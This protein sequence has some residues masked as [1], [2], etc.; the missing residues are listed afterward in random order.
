MA[1]L[2]QLCARHVHEGLFSHFLTLVTSVEP[3]GRRRPD[4]VLRDALLDAFTCLEH[5]YWSHHYTFG[6]TRL[7]T[8]KAL[9]GRGRATDILVNVLL[10]MLL[11][12]TQLED[13]TRTARRLRAVWRGLP[14][15]PDNT[16]TRRMS[17][18]MFGDEASARKV[19]NS[20]PRQQGLHQLYRDCC[21]PDTGCEQCIVYLAHRSGRGLAAS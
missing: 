8:A 21:R 3:E 20:V 2:A 11:A 9:V 16:V 5:P 13:A 15:R 4:V 19:V 7:S 17:Q 1:A 6:G 12:H 10:P 18:V 14:R